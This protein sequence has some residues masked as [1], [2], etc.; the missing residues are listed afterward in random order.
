MF[1]KQNYQKEFTYETIK[2]GVAKAA[3]LN[4]LLCLLYIRL[5]ICRTNFS[6]A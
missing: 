2:E 3:E 5:T 1:P 4:D 6:V